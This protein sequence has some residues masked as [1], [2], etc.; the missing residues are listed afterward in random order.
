LPYHPTIT[1]NQIREVEDVTP[2]AKA[3][4]GSAQC[5]RTRY[6]HACRLSVKEWYLP[7]KAVRTS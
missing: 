1:G 5:S 2:P 6:V 3:G 7:V 4:A